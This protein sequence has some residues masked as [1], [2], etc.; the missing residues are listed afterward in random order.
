MKSTAAK[1]PHTNSESAASNKVTGGQ[2]ACVAQDQHRKQNCPGGIGDIRGHGLLKPQWL[3][4]PDNS[5]DRDSVAKN[6]ANT[7]TGISQP[8]WLVKRLTVKPQPFRIG[9]ILPHTPPPMLS[10][11][12]AARTHPLPQGPACISPKSPLQYPQ[13]KAHMR[14]PHKPSQKVGDVQLR[15]I[16]E[17]VNT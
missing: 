13:P 6:A 11:G 1:M 5:K 8:V 2:Y 14:V 17:A 3:Q 9:I 16:A 12:F 4:L 15:R 7:M 10:D